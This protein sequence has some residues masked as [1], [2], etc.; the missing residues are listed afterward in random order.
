MKTRIKLWVKIVIFL[1]I[2]I[3]TIF[4]YGRFINTSGFIVK[5]YSIK[6]NVPSE[7]KII[8]ISDINYKHTT[9]KKDLKNIINKINFI[10]PD[11]VIFTGDLLNESITYSENDINDITKLLN[12]IDAKIDK[13]AIKGEE[14]DNE[15]FEKIMNDS[16]FTILNNDYKLIYKKIK[17]PIL[18]AGINDTNENIDNIYEYLN[19]NNIF[20]ILLLHKPD[21]IKDINYNKFNLI[22]SGHSINGYINIP[23]IKNLF[24][25]EGSKKYYEEYYKIDNTKL[26]IS[27]GIGTKNIKFRF[28]NKPS[29]NFYR[30]IKK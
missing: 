26:Y 17:T 3:T 6:G 29:I 10:D 20:S 30:I 8:Q 4:I 24:L 13:I 9:N 15:Y 12:K 18:I 22:F 14:D 2:L 11:I 25:E 16:N 23:G 5:E 27:N 19:N 21:N 28:L 1:I 7:F